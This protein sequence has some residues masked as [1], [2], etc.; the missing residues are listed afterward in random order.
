MKKTIFNIFLL[1]GFIATFISC[2]KEGEQVTLDPNAKAPELVTVPDLAFARDK[3]ADTLVFVGKEAELGFTASINYILEA[4]ATADFEEA[5]A[6]ANDVQCKEFKLTVGA[7]NTELLKKFP[8]DATSTVFFRIRG[9]VIIDSGTGALGTSTNPMEYISDNKEASV[10][11]F[12]L[13][14][15]VLVGSG[16]DQKI[17]SPLNDGIYSSY[18]KLDPA[19]PFTLINNETGVSYGGAG[20]AISVDGPAIVP[21]ASGWHYLVVDV[22]AL[23]MSLEEYSIGVVGDATENGWDGPDYPLEY[24]SQSATWSLTID[25]VPGYFKFRKN[26]GWG[27]NMGTADGASQTAFEGDLQQGG[28]GNDI[29]ILEAGNYSITMTIYNDDAGHY[30]MVKN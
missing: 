16:M 4:S 7:V 1:L 25:L 22:N 9:V 13:P 17:Y 14:N 21:G 2:E 29:Q 5:V 20:E 30:K 23:T 8:E 6:L 12:G 24:D 19:S 26:G 15:L 3:G 27:W 28:V 10:T 18:V 11:L